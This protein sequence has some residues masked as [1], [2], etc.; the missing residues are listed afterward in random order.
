[1][2][3]AEK[4]D[5]LGFCSVANSIHHFFHQKKLTTKKRGFREEN[6]CLSIN[7]SGG[8]DCVI[9]MVFNTAILPF[10]LSLLGVVAIIIKRFFKILPKSCPNYDVDRTWL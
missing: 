3:T 6:V 2:R 7:V 9:L 10:W 4:G 5:V 8:I 1:M